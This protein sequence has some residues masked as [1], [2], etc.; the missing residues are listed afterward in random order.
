MR[1]VVDPSGRG[2]E[3]YL[4][5]RD[6]KAVLASQVE[7]RPSSCKHRQM[8]AGRHEPGDVRCRVEDL[9]H[10][11]QEQECTFLTQASGQAVREGASPGL[12]HAQRLRHGWYDELRLA[13]GCQGDQDHAIRKEAVHP[14]RHL[15]RQARLAHTAGPGQRE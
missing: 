5:W 14:R 4:Q 7:R 2:D 13:D 6:W 12:L 11:V 9:L 3:R 8:G 10:V 15:Q 1:Q